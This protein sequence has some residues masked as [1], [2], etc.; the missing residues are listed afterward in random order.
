MG[1]APPAKSAAFTTEG[2]E[3]LM[4]AGFTLNTKKTM[5]QPPTF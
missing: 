3:L 4:M 5:F 1:S 2:H